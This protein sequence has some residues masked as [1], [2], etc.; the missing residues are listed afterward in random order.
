VTY[1]RIKTTPFV[2]TKELSHFSPFS[3]TP[4]T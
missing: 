3:H 4:H 1:C 2:S